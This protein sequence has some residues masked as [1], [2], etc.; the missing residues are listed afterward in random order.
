MP[1][2][3]Q[4]CKEVLKGVVDKDNDSRI[5]GS[6]E[7]SLLQ[8]DKLIHSTTFPFHFPRLPLPFT[9]L[10]FLSPPLSF[11][12][13]ILSSLPLT[14]LLCCNTCFPKK[15]P[16]LSF[17][18]PFLVVLRYNDHSYLRA[19][20][21]FWFLFS[22]LSGKFSRVFVY[23]HPLFHSCLSIYPYQGNLTFLP[24]IALSSFSPSSSCQNFLYS[25]Y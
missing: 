22:F 9:P 19:F 4:Q 11:P 21:V 8:E 24:K 14:F 6:F 1:E 12:P 3:M 17:L 5:S 16:F 18:I 13:L 15:Q 7:L 25:T 23:A 10:P 20:W 2:V